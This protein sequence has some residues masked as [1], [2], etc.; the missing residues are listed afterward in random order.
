[1]IK[2]IL[3]YASGEV[4]VKGIAFLAIPLYSHLI[5]P[6]EYGVLGFLKSV[7]SF[8]P[9]IL[10]FYYLYAYVRLSVEV[11]DKKLI[12]TY[13]FLGLFLNIFYLL[14][15]LGLYILVIQS[16]EIDLYYFILSIM[17]SASI[18]MFQ[19]LQMYYRSKGMAS[20]YL[21]FSVIYSFLGLGL[22]FAALIFFQDNI[23][24]MLFS[25]FL[26]SLSLSIIAYQKLKHHVEWA[27]FDLI[28]VK[29]ILAYSVPLVPGA[30][31]LLLFSQ[32]DKIFLINYVSTV[33]LGVY[34]MAFTIGL[35]MSYIGSAFFMS[36][37][38]LFYEKM[39]A[40]LKEEVENQFWKNVLF[41]LSALALD[42]II[43]LIVYQFVNPKYE[44]GLPLAFVI[45][46]AYTFISFAQMMELHLTHIKKTFLVSLVYGI[47]GILTLVCLWFF[48]P[49]FGKY[50][51]AYSLLISAVVISMLMYYIAQK[52]LYLS[53]NR[54]YVL[55]FY[56]VGLGS[57]WLIL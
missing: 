48:I 40:G 32:S 36:Y 21:K 27:L 45:A 25:S 22:N 7:T 5:Q 46:I 56:V 38:P 35:S 14:S 39:S 1:M 57:A 12:S 2:K 6:G 37:Q 51:A 11:E 43:I 44:D 4:L 49:I 24:A 16:F 28:L 55:G 50:G 52:N 10:T 47:G 29:K 42:F 9:F 53:Y 26:V 54:L 18:Y 3:T 34:T 30:I 41:L 20:S 13:F 31:A 8:L 23:F 19:V 17:A 33:E 15:A